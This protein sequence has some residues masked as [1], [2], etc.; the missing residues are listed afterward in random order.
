MVGDLE[1]NSDEVLDGSR[2]KPE[3]LLDALLAASRHEELLRFLGMEKEASFQP[4]EIRVGMQVPDRV[5]WKGNELHILDLK[6]RVDSRTCG[7]LEVKNAVGMLYYIHHGPM[8]EGYLTKYEVALACVKTAV[9]SVNHPSQ[10]FRQLLDRR[11]FRYL[12][13]EYGFISQHPLDLTTSPL[14]LLLADLRGR[15]RQ[16]SLSRKEGLNHE[17]EH[18]V[19]MLDAL[20]S[21]NYRPEEKLFLQRYPHLLE[22]AFP[23]PQELGDY[24]IKLKEVTEL[25]ESELEQIV[26]EH[27]YLLSP[28]ERLKGLK[29]E[30]RLK[31]LKPEE[32]EELLRLLLSRR[33]QKDLDQSKNEKDS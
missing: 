7:E 2:W 18:L 27:L 4:S 20:I 3:S 10:R 16:L 21:R 23:I 28:E 32:E 24:L 9:F 5:F 15:I 22:F 11:S 30:E 8:L 13:I 12:S 33:K 14:P 6:I 1:T 25:S 19:A 26:K 29:P 17:W 31:G